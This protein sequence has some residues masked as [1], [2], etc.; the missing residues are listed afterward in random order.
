MVKQGLIPDN[1]DPGDRR[2]ESRR[3]PILTAAR[4]AQEPG[5]LLAAPA[6]TVVSLLRAIHWSDQPGAAHRR[7]APGFALRT[8]NR[9]AHGA[10]ARQWRN[11]AAVAGRPS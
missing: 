8:G 5:A 7:S 10:G 3:Q 6:V 2:S 4:S 11:A 9:A 1:I